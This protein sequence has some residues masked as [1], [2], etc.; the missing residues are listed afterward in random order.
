MKA[1]YVRVNGFNEEITG[2]GK[3]DDELGVRLRN[4][5]LRPVSVCNRAVNFHLWHSKAHRSREVI[6]RNLD[7]KRQ[8]QKSGEYR[9]R[10]GY[11][12]H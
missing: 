5:G 1:D 10:V 6:D 3:E 8:Y 12:R 7:F 4:A 11:D 9:C 2:W